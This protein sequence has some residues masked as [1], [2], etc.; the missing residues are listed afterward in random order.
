VSNPKSL[1]AAYNIN[2][3]TK[4]KQKLTLEGFDQV[5]N[6]KKIQQ[7]DEDH[8]EQVKHDTIVA[9][10]RA[11]KMAQGGILE[12]NMEEESILPELNEEALDI[13]EGPELE[14]PE[15]SNQHLVEIESD[16][17]DMVSKIRAKIAKQK[18]FGM[19]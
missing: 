7:R 2:K 15:D 17:N 13:P 11:K 18:I 19:E 9:A 10:I 5:E 1:A 8:E 14:Q 3:Q 16:L 6:S 12:Q 4:P